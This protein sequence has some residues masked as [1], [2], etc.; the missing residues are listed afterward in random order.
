MGCLGEKGNFGDKIALR[1][2]RCDPGLVGLP[3]R[4]DASDCVD[5]WWSERCESRQQMNERIESLW[6]SVCSCE[7][8]NC[9]LVCHSNVIKLLAALLSQR[10]FSASGMS[11]DVELLQRAR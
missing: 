3:S 4:V 8:S 9:I 10:D 7:T 11:D 2:L 6:K 1:A 5:Q